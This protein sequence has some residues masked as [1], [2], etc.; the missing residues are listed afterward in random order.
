[1]HCCLFPFARSHPS[2][3]SLLSF[4]DRI[5]FYPSTT[6]P[7]EIPPLDPY[8]AR[9]SEPPSP[10]P[11]PSFGSVYRP[12]IREDV[13]ENTV[14]VHEAQ[15]GRGDEREDE[16]FA[17]VLQKVCSVLHC[18]SEQ[19]R[20]PMYRRAEAREAQLEKAV[21]EGKAATLFSSSSSSKVL[22]SLSSCELS[23]GVEKGKEKHYMTPLVIAAP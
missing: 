12:F 17:L 23:L 9:L 1:M 14:D 11:S 20:E 7:I 6:L 5:P 21:T 13:S 4:L 19:E 22:A 2:G 8:L 16:G 15:T 3:L 18:C 10:P